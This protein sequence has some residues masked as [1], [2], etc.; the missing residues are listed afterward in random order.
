MKKTSAIALIIIIIGVLVAI[1]VIVEKSGAEKPSQE[2]LVSFAQ[3]LASKNITMYGAQWCSHCQREKSLFGEAFKYVPYIECPENEKLC[4]DAGIK[5][6]PTW[7]DDSGTK[8]ADEQGLDGLA[9][10]SGCPL[11]PPETK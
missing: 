11:L 7:I 3:C 2:V 1:V 8:Y 5:G 9:K 4:L 6:Y 10:I